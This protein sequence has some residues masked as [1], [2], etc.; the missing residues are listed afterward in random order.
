[1]L[2]QANKLIYND[3]IKYLQVNQVDPKIRTATNRNNI[4][5]FSPFMIEFTDTSE[6]FDISD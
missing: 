4:V 3:S 2:I 6:S 5:S 1:M